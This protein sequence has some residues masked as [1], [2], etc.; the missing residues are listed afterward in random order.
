MA[1]DKRHDRDK[2]DPAAQGQH[3][4]PTEEAARAS[5]PAGMFVYKKCEGCK[6][7]YNYGLRAR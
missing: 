7:W 2:C 1:E 4:F 6:G 5:D 3:Y